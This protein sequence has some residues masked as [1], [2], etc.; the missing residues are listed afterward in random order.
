MTRGWLHFLC[1]LDKLKEILTAITFYLVHQY[2]RFIYFRFYLRILL[3]LNPLTS[4]CD[5]TVDMATS[6][7]WHCH[8]SSHLVEDEVSV[9]GFK[10]MTQ[11]VRV[12]LNFTD[13]NVQF[14]SDLQKLAQASDLCNQWYSRCRYVLKYIYIYIYWFDLNRNYKFSKCFG[15]TNH[16]NPTSFLQICFQN[17]YVFTLLSGGFTTLNP[18]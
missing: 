5:D 7:P 17:R 11:N 10:T 15:S 9:G 1:I 13:S 16:I 14:I 12:I 3:S 8:Q 2:I 4:N 18:F 6:S